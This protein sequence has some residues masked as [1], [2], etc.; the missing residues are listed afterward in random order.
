MTFL[1]LVRFP[2]LTT[3]TIAVPIATADGE[4][5]VGQGKLPNVRNFSDSTG[6][7]CSNLLC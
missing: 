5:G 3:P 2:A 1:V 6:L 7:I 4:G